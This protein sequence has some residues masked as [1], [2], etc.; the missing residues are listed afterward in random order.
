MIKFQETFEH[1]Y[2]VEI[3]DNFETSLE[4]NFSYPECV[5][6]GFVRGIGVDIFPNSDNCEPWFGSF[7]E[8]T[9]SPNAID[10]CSSHPDPKKL[11]II[12]KGAGYI[13]NV[14]KPS[15]YEEISLTPIMGVLALN[16]YG[17]IILHSFS[18]FIA[19]GINGV[20]WETPNVS[21]DGIKNCKIENKR[22]KAEV[23]NSPENIF[24]PVEVLIETGEVKGG[25]SP[26][27]LGID[28]NK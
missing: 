22:I 13:V 7:S 1:A 8:G 9:I 27:L 6:G 4:K 18:R 28:T 12:S 24:S 23:W 3:V 2:Q 17:I 14:E 20:I 10:Y 19:I 15:E 26:E 25:S 21:W 5:N 16:E 11:M